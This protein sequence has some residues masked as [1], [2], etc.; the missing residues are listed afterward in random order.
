[1][2]DQKIGL[3]YNTVCP[4]VYLYLRKLGEFIV[5]N[6]PV[7]NI[8]LELYTY[9]YFKSFKHFEQIVCIEIALYLYLVCKLIVSVIAAIC[10]DEI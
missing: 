5:K 6:K 3:F 7:V 2:K 9:M 8:I 4:I 10:S 1:M